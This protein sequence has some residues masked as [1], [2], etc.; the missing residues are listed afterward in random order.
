MLT[1]FIIGAAI[2]IINGLCQYYRWEL[3]SERL[4]RVLLETTTRMQ[5]ERIQELERERARLHLQLL[6][7]LSEP[8]Q[9]VNVYRN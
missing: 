8:G 7:H 6:A 3:E 4:D 9:N 2:I 5:A 1:I